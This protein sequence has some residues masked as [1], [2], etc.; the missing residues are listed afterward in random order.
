MPPVSKRPW[1]G[2]APSPAPGTRSSGIEPASLRSGMGAS[3]ESRPRHLRPAS[4]SSDSVP[5]PSNSVVHGLC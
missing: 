1:P 4:P 3:N 5:A 2:M